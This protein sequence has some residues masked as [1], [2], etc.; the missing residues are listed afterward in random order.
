MKY[1][2][3]GWKVPPVVTRQIDTT[4][5]SASP[6]TA[7]EPRRTLDI[8]WGQLVMV[9]VTSRPGSS[10]MKLGSEKPQA[11]KFIRILSRQAETEST[12]IQDAN[13]VEPVNLYPCLNLQFLVSIYK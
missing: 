8:F 2:T 4:A 1:E 3:D 13:P 12:Q 7:G 5:P 9:G 6:T 10:Q 11:I